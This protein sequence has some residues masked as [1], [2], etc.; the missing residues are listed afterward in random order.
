MAKLRVLAENPPPA[1]GNGENQLRELR[2]YLTRLKDELEFLMLHI[3]AD[4]LDADLTEQ[5]SGIHTQA[6]GTAEAVKGL[7]T[8]LT[9]KAENK[10]IKLL[11]GQTLTIST[12]SGAVYALLVSCAGPSPLNALYYLSGYSNNGTHKQYSTLLASA[13]IAVTASASGFTVTNNH[14]SYGMR[15]GVL[16]MAEDPAGKLSYE[17][18]G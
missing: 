14:G 4:N 9:G 17:V 6:D 3:G 12:P 16:A 10:V 15:V 5:L 13:S 2:D 7:S 1:R 18:I 11:A 8:A